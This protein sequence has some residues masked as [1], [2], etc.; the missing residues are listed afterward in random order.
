MYIRKR[1]SIFELAVRNWKSVILI[2]VTVAAATLV[3]LELLRPYVKVSMIVVTGFST[4]ISFFIAFFTHQAYDRW[5]EARKIWGTIVND[6]RSFGRMVT[7]LFGKDGGNSEVTAIQD[8]LIRRHIAHLYVVKEQLRKESAKEYSAYLSDE[9][10][11]RVSGSSNAGNALL[12]LQG[13]DIDAAERAGHIDVIRM[14]QLN[15]MLSRFSTS[16]GMAERIKLTVFPAYYAAMIRVSIWVFVLVFPVA[17]SEQIGYWAILFAALLAT[18]F[19]LI[20]QSGQAMLYPFEG[21]PSDTP[22]SSIVRTIEIN[23]LEQIGE[24]NTPAPVEP[25]EGR[26]LM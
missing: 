1:I 3:Y 24:K 16:M 22:M 4:A 12:R 19:Y 17:L 2:V 13:E 7:T 15:D 26:Y 14:A 6:S 10:T 21:A 18:I 20:F 23:L 25:V 5:W 9:D 8:R 11:S